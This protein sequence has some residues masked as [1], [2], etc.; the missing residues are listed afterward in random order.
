MPETLGITGSGA[1]ACGLAKAAAGS[2]D[3]L[4]WARSPT[5]AD[6]A[7]PRLEDAARV[8]TDLSATF[9]PAGAARRRTYYGLFRQDPVLGGPR[10]VS[11]LGPDNV[12][13]AA[14]ELPKG[15][16]KK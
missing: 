9:T 15:A 8:V 3:V 2:H 6:R 16:D 14:F 13:A 7:C 5:S 10:L 12:P 11:Q 1:I 4:L